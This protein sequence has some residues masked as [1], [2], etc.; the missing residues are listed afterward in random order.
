LPHDVFLNGVLHSVQTS[1]LTKNAIN[2]RNAFIDNGKTELDDISAE[3][4]KHPLDPIKALQIQP[5]SSETK[6]SQSNY[7]STQDSFAAD[8][9]LSVA[10]THLSRHSQKLSA[11]PA[12]KSEM[13]HESLHKVEDRIQ[14]LRKKHPSQNIQQLDRHNIQNSQPSVGD[15]H[16]LDDH[17]QPL[18]QKSLSEN[19]QLVDEKT[20]ADNFQKLAP[21]EIRRDTILY[22]EKKNI[23]DNSQLV[24][25]PNPSRASATVSPPIQ[26]E[27]KSDL[28]AHPLHADQPIQTKSPSHSLLAEDKLRARV[29][30]MKEN[31][32][33]V[34][35]SLTDIEEDI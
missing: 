32:G 15:V 23:H 9:F 16:R 8:E 24:A 29:R 10:K 17:M 18:H 33:K 25:A 3:F 26:S 13:F 34:N 21:T 11:E 20:V 27:N 30:K 12:S 28:S 2:P 7:P 22:K 5:E 35:Q 6:Q 4:A 14:N 1:E 31:I 19:R